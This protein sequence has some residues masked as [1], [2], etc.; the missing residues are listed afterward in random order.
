MESITSSFESQINCL[1]TS[2][3]KEKIDFTKTILNF[4]E[5][6]QGKLTKLTK[7]LKGLRKDIFDIKNT[8]FP[9]EIIEL[10]ISEE[11]KALRINNSSPFSLISEYSTKETN[12]T[13]ASLC[14]QSF[15]C[16]P[17]VH[18]PKNSP[19]HSRA[20]TLTQGEKSPFFFPVP[21]SVSKDTSYLTE[22]IKSPRNVSELSEKSTF[23]LK[24]DTNHN[25]NINYNLKLHISKIKNQRDKIK[26]DYEKLLLELKEAKL[27]LAVEKEKSSEKLN[28]IENELNKILNFINRISDDLNLNKNSKQEI[29]NLF[30]NIKRV[31]I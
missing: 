2:N 27:L 10:E 25:E 15:S 26:N 9:Q 6:I 4:S 21:D 1:N 7:N 16:K 11:K 19:K 22:N 14:E 23:K 29:G 13:K 8:L 31:L 12:S 3:I 5:N 20:R 18:S 28:K 30:R 24:L 17:P